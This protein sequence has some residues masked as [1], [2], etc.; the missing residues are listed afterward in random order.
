MTQRADFLKKKTNEIDKT[1][2]GVTKKKERRQIKS[3]IKGQASQ[4]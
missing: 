1:L 3:E 4:V 2:V